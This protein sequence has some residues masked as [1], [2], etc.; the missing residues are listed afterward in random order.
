MAKACQLHT[1]AF[2][3][4]LLFTQGC[5]WT[6]RFYV[7]NSGTMPRT[8]SI[9][10]ER[11]GSGFAIFDPAQFYLVPVNEG[12]PDYEHVKRLPRAGLQ[13]TVEIPAHTALEIGHLS[14][15]RYQSS[16]QQFIN[17]R[18]FNLKKIQYG[19]NEITAEDFDNYFQKKSYGYAWEL[20]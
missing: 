2:A 13:N 14:N 12:K 15:E 18:V 11:P 8:V 7:V 1:L 20:P 16:R 4:L 10:V 17:G 19:A 5:S 6:I 3:A 9:A